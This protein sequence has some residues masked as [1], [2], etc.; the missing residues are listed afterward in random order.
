MSFPSDLDPYN[1]LRNLF[2]GGGTRGRREG[3]GFGSGGWNFDDMFR[4]FD[5]MRKEKEHFL[6][7]LR[8]LKIKYQKI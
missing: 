2:G 4:E 7:N 8:I 3:K 1:F 5:E 6:N